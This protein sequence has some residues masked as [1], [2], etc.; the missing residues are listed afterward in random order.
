MSKNT[1]KRLNMSLML[2]YI[3]GLLITVAGRA[4]DLAWQ[5]MHCEKRRLDDQVTHAR[6][7]VKVYV[8]FCF[9]EPVSVSDSTASNGR[10]I[11]ERR[12]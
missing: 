1:Y 4:S 9:Y 11:D 6:M 2:R 12:I 10:M 3:P 8:V 5:Q 7:S